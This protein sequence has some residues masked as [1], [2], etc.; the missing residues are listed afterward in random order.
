MS[1]KPPIIERV[2]GFAVLFFV[3][4]LLAHIIA[5]QIIERNLAKTAAQTA[6]LQSVGSTVAAQKDPDDVDLTPDEPRQTDIFQPQTFEFKGYTVRELARFSATAVLLSK[7]DY[8]AD[9]A[10]VAN[11]EHRRVLSPA[12]F[13]LGWGPMSNPSVLKH[14]TYFQNNRF[15]FYAATVDFVERSHELKVDSH[16]ANVHIIPA[17]DAVADAL[18]KVQPRDIV[19]I[20][21]TLI[22]VSFHGQ[23]LWKSS[24]SRTDT[25]DGACE[26]IML[27]KLSWISQ[28]DSTR[29]IPLPHMPQLPAQTQE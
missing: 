24:L 1:D 23:V 16:V 27:T 9:N 14:F 25:G 2:F 5:S 26:L 4:V 21:G 12:D 3:G 18:A 7:H 22:E 19:S 13:A 6:Q 20:E 28:P 15:F 17:D 8:A 29:H 10:S 11:T